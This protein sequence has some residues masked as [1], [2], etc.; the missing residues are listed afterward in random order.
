MIG[1][2]ALRPARVAVMCTCVYGNEK[3]SP[4]EIA[5]P[6]I[7]VSTP[8]VLSRPAFDLAAGP[9]GIATSHRRARPSPQAPLKP[10]L[11]A[12]RYGRGFM[13]KR[14]DNDLCII[15]IQCVSAADLECGSGS[16]VP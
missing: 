5:I 7:F 9:S 8:P 10:R 16:Y 4:H 15:S 12:A 2:L 6:L 3:W 13:S 1:K 14:V 11:L